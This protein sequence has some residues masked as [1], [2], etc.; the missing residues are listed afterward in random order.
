MKRIYEK[1]VFIEQSIGSVNKFQVSYH[2]QITTELDG[3]PVKDII[4]KYGLV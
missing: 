2:E 1:P 3:V 4:A